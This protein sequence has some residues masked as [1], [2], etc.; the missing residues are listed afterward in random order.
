MNETIDQQVDTAIAEVNAREVPPVIEQAS[1]EVVETEPQAEPQAAEKEV[2]TPFP[3][4]AINALSRRDKKI[5]ML[6]QERAQLLQELERLRASSQGNVQK[7]DGPPKIE[8][9]ETF[10]EY[11]DAKM[12][13]KLR[14]HAQESTKQLQ[15][16]QRTVQQQQ[17]M[18]EQDEAMS[19]EIERIAAA[20][21]S[22]KQ[23][24]V[25]N[26]DV[27]QS[28]TPELNMVAYQLQ[29][30]GINPVEGC[31]QLAREGS[32]DRLLSVPPMAAAAM[33]SSAVERAKSFR[34]PTKAPAPI[35]GVSG[36]GAKGSRVESMST[37]ELLKWQKS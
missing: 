14:N 12:E 4:K 23:L 36:A 34:K 15:E 3:K 24:I 28:F 17:W 18:A 1:P 6:Q 22:V 33:I 29:A 8:D 25:E 30:N 20:D 26:A 32:L 2:D 5:G 7:S 11:N 21:P 9:F 13:Y 37:Q 27:I 16:Q 35:N 31:L 19:S 10:E